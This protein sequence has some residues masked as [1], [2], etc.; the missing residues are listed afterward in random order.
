MATNGAVQVAAQARRP[1]VSAGVP[2]LA[3]KITAPSVPDWA[4]P[5]PRI[6]KLIARGTRWC[7]LT[8]L[9]A[10]AG[11]RKTMAL[12]LWAAARP[13]PVTWVCLDEYDNRPGVFWA[14]VVA[15]LR[16]SGVAVPGALPAARG[17]DA[18]RVFLLWLASVLAGQDPPVTLVLDD[19]HLL[20]DPAVLDGLAYVLRNAGSGLRLV[21]SAR[22]DPLPL[23]RYRLGGELTEIRASDLAFTTAEAGE[24]LGRHGITLTADSIECLTRR[25]EGWAAGL[26]LAALSMGTRRLHGGRSGRCPCRGTGRQGPGRQARPAS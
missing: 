8:V 13:G 19:L 12:T 1:A 11:A 9:T 26:R 20:T 21:A 3:S 23:H 7:P 24:L 4:L 6:T 14:Y 16:Q 15:A 17:P 22:A 10:P 5:R 2:I 25:T 18:G